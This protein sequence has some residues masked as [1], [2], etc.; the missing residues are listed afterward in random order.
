MELLEV[1]HPTSAPLIFAGA[2]T[3]QNKKYEMILQVP[4]ASTGF[5]IPSSSL[6]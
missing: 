5:S 4:L 6:G 1:L 2:W 3:N